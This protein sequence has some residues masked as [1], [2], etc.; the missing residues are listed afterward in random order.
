M[1]AGSQKLGSGFLKSV[2]QEALEKEF[3]DQQIPSIGHPKLNIMFDGKPPGNFFVADFVC[4]NSIIL[5]LKASILFI[6]TT[7]NKPSII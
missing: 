5:K 3:Q 1:Y 6:T 7:Q 4:F 2:Y